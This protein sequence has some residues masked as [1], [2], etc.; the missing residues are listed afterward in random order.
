MKLNFRVSKDFDYQASGKILKTSGRVNQGLFMSFTRTDSPSRF[1]KCENEAFIVHSPDEHPASFEFNQY[2]DMSFGGFLDVLV[3]PQVIETDE[4]LRSFSPSDRQCY[5]EGEIK[6][7]YFK[8]YT[9]QNCMSECI[10]DGVFKKCGCVPFYFI[11]DSSMN[12]CNETARNSADKERLGIL[13][14]DNCNFCLPSCNQITY[15]IE[16]IVIRVNKSFDANL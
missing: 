15:E 8:V 4:E 5:F 16:T 6:L 1:Y 2:S 10:S 3:L 12:V 7:K 14:S 9:K 11:R 13:K